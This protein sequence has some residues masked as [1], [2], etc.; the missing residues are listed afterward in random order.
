MLNLPTVWSPLVMSSLHPPC[1][2]WCFTLESHGDLGII[3]NQPTMYDIIWYNWFV[4]NR[5]GDSCHQAWWGNNCVYIYTYSHE[6]HPIK[7]AMVPAGR[8]AAA[9]HPRSRTCNARDRARWDRKIDGDLPVRYVICWPMGKNKQIQQKKKAICR[10]GVERII[11]DSCSNTDPPSRLAEQLA[12]WPPTPTPAVSPPKFGSS[13][14]SS[15]L[16]KPHT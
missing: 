13:V 1:W 3:L 8:P 16:N 4:P 10:R 9:N 6:S 7:C 14:Q 15:P 11:S 5:N 2:G 12:S